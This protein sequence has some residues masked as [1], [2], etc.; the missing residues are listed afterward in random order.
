M[1]TGRGRHSACAEAGKNY[2][3]TC[4]QTNK[5]TRPTLRLVKYAACLPSRQM[6]SY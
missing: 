1:C 4:V 6:T 2:A 5:G 3:A